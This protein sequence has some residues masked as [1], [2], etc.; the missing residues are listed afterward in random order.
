MK[1]IILALALVATLSAA[2]LTG[3]GDKYVDE[4]C[5]MCGTSPST[6][7]EAM[8][9]TGYFCEDHVEAAKKLADLAEDM[10]SMLG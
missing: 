6:A 5:E 7:V 2:V 3:C 1:K 10:G 8:G 4:P 9:E